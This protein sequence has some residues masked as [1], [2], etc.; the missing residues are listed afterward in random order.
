[1]KRVRVRSLGYLYIPSV[2][3]STHRLKLYRYEH[4]GHERQH[5]LL[6]RTSLSVAISGSS[7]AQKDMC[8]KGRLSKL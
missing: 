5:V 7:L 8:R 3:F 4:V 6:S 1:M 2:D